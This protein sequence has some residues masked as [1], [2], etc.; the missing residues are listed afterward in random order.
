MPGP[1]KSKSNRREAAISRTVALE[2]LVSQVDGLRKSA[3]SSY[4]NSE[5]AERSLANADS[6]IGEAVQSLSLGHYDRVDRL[7]NVTW[8]YAKFAL[9]ILGAEATEHLLG[10]DFFLDLIEPASKI[11]A[12]LKE[13]VASVGTM[14]DQIESR[15]AQN[16]QTEP[17]LEKGD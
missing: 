17:G 1:N 6:A 4:H 15:L 3:S 10:D 16:R 11:E 2:Q 14:L 7:L 13:L 12:N 9:D 8:F 5:L